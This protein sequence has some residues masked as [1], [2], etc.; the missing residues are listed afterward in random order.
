MF[1]QVE[2]SVG[3]EVILIRA[4]FF[5]NSLSGGGAEKVC[6]TLARRLFELNI[7][8]DFVT[9]FDK[10]ADYD[11]PEY[12]HVFSLCLKEPFLTRLSMIRLVPKVNAFI[13]DKQ[14]IL[15]S[16]HLQPAYQLAAFTK[17]GKKCLY[18][19]H[20]SQS[21][22][23]KNHSWF[24]K[25]KLRYF[26]KDKRIITVSKGLQA[27]LNNEYG[28]CQENITTIYNPCDVFLQK[29]GK[30]QR[31]LHHRPYILIMGRLEE[32]KNPLLALELYY[33]GSFY[34]NY[35]LIYLGK[36]SLENTLKR[37]IIAYNMQDF[38]YL[39][40]FQKDTE[41]WLINASLLMSCSKQEGLPLNLVEAL[42][43]GTPV[44]AADCPHGPKEILVG[45]L[46]KYLIHPENDLEESIAAV[47]RALNYY[48]EIAEE[49]FTKFDSGLIVKTYMDVWKKYFE[50]E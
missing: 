22:D 39:M 19:M 29:S 43:C 46:A 40:G 48:P 3:E 4:L 45:D 23:D 38:V 27:E 30:K 20:V 13:S 33:R 11:I 9:V 25:M 34:K 41:N 36:G 50:S 35:D 2:Q 42:M 17:A 5:L 7:E 8:S 24:Y 26:L 49:Y 28:I 37:K 14:Y 15:I 16:A 31:V 32:Q 21:L 47:S 44:V 6:L 12:I 10:K 1:R 18:V